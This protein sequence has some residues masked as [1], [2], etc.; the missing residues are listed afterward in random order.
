MVLNI[1]DPYQVVGALSRLT[2]SLLLSDGQ[3]L[4]L[5]TVDSISEL[6][7]SDVEPYQISQT[8]LSETLFPLGVAPARAWL[9][10]LGIHLHMHKPASCLLG[11]INM[12]EHGF[13][14]AFSSDLWLHIPLESSFDRF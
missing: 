13:V 2:R 1:H 7:L 14:T 8:R 12:V 3:V 9:L 4:I 5:R 6:D 11:A 10:A